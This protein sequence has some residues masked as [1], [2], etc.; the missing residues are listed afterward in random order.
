MRSRQRRRRDRSN[1]APRRRNR[2]FAITLNNPVNADYVRWSELLVSGKDAD[3]AGNLRYFCF[4]TEIGDGSEGDSRLG[5]KHYQAYIA[6][7]KPTD[8][9][10]VKKILGD[11]IHIGNCYASEAR[12]VLYCTKTRTRHTGTEFC[13]AG[14]WG[15]LA[16]G[17]GTMAVAVKI[18][19]GAKLSDLVEDHPGVAMMHFQEMCE[20]IALK[21]GDRT[22]KPEVII[23]YGLTG[24]GK[25]QYCKAM[26]P[27]DLDLC[28]WV[29][30]PGG[31][32]DH[33][34]I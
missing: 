10:V 7:T 27:S 4:Q 34:E 11:R 29:A 22:E 24:C 25:S 8:W 9:S 30:P 23:L 1:R 21:K 3:H 15:T 6:F 28:Y 33:H 16:R 13:Q 5:T 12:N 26:W 17:G 32:R 14:S 2:R 18:R 19:G 20:F 31:K